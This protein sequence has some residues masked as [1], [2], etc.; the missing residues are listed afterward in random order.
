MADSHVLKHRIAVV[1]AT[2]IVGQAVLRA[3][4]DHDIPAESIVPMGSGRHPGQE[5]S[6]GDEVYPVM[7][8]ADAKWDDYS[9]VILCVP[10]SVVHAHESQFMNTKA[11]VLDA[12]GYFALAPGVP[13]WVD[14]MDAASG[15]KDAR[16]TALPDPLVTGVTHALSEL[17]AVN[18]IE[19]LSITSLEG[20][21]VYGKAAM[22]ELMQETKDGMMNKVTAP[23][24]FPK[25]MAFNVLPHVGPVPN[26]MLNTARED[27]VLMQI[28]KLWRRDLPVQVTRTTVPVFTGAGL[29]LHVTC[30]NKITTAHM[31]ALQ[32]NSWRIHPRHAE[33]VEAY[34]T[35]I[36]VTNDDHIH[37]SRMR[38]H[39]KHKT[40]LA[41]WAIFDPVHAGVAMPAVRW[42][43]K[44]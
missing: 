6:V 9:H 17:D 44:N 37:L 21:G 43:N 30:K 38:V 15:D 36:D 4:A 11:R 41:L 20:V 16:V 33:G 25:A 12:S 27:H 8:M 3:L 29:S 40:Q 31:K 32:T 39:P 23:E 10:A 18:P 35:H 14:G 24:I 42:L 7:K 22:R 13:L 28:R 26:Q 2:G 5:A 1:G 34:A 19:A